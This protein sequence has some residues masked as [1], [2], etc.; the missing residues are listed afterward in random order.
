MATVCNMIHS[1][2]LQ[3]EILLREPHRLRELEAFVNIE[4][5]VHA[6]FRT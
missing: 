6:R 5:P 4:G 3:R 2:H 1:S